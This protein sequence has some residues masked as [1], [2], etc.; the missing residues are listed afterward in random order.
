MN[1]SNINAISLFQA[2][3]FKGLDIIQE[4]KGDES[5]NKTKKKFYWF[6]FKNKDKKEDK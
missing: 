1:T 3:G 6:S 5:K 2:S 4:E